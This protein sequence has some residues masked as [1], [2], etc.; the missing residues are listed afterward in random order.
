L[1]KTSPSN[2]PAWNTSASTRTGSTS[3]M[4]TFAL[5]RRRHNVDHGLTGTPE[6]RPGLREARA[7][8]RSGDSLVVTKLDRLARSLQSSFPESWNPSAKPCA[9]WYRQD[10]GAYARTRRTTLAAKQ[11]QR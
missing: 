5:C 6:P 11:S 10:R 1:S 8:C 2:A 9:A 4:P 3:I 7:A